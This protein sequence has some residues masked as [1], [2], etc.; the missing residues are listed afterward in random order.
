MNHESLENLPKGWRVGIVSHNN[1]GD[2]NAPVDY[3]LSAI[4]ESEEAA[5]QHAAA[6]NHAAHEDDGMFADTAIVEPIHS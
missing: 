6:W 4:Y 2:L 5:R 1:F 3:Y